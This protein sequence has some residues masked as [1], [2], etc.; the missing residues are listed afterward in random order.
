ME[1]GRLNIRKFILEVVKMSMEDDIFALAS[2]LAYGLL[3]ALFPF[4]IFLMTLVGYSSIKSSDV[5]QIF[6]RIMPEQVFGLVKGII[7]EV[8]ERK[9]GNLLSF[10]LFISIWSSMSGFNAIIKGLNMS[11][12]EEE[13][14]GFLKVQLISFIF[15]IGLVIMI[16]SITFLMVFA[17]VNEPIVAKW[18]HHREI[19]TFVWDFI[20]YFLLVFTMLFIFSAVYRYTP[21]KKHRWSDV[22]WGALFTTVGWIVSSFGFSYYINNFGN[23]SKIYGSIGAVIVL[24]TWLF[25][26]SFILILGGEINSAILNKN[27]YK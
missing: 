25:M 18:F 27:I 26:G 16:F 3:F 10:S 24:M 12:R 20:K 15:T 1:K 17:S 13:R 9:N 14:R 2:Q 8:T 23:Y 6:Q 5:L 21:V 22:I 7:L 11:Y 4:L 19:T